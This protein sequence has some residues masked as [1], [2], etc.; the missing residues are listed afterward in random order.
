MAQSTVVEVKA[1]SFSVVEV[2]TANLA[3]DANLRWPTIDISF[4][5]IGNNMQSLQ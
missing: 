2:F 3:V 4:T 5:I 1:K